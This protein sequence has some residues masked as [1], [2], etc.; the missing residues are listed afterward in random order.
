MVEFTFRYDAAANETG[1]TPSTAPSPAQEE[2]QQQT[3]PS[4]LSEQLVL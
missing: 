2:Q 3:S 4:P 1:T